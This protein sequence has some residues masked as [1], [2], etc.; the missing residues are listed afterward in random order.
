MSIIHHI[1]RLKDKN[2]IIISLDA[3]KK[4]LT[5][6]NILPQ[7]KSWRDYEY[8]KHIST[9]KAIYKS[10]ANII[11]NREQLQAF[12]L[13]SGIRQGSLFS[14]NL[15]KIVFSASFSNNTTEGDQEDVNKKGRNH[16]ILICRWYNF[17]F[18]KTQPG[19]PY[20]W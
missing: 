16:S 11:F 8:K 3:E 10:T 5:K 9:T 6:S 18:K 14:P 17:I 2:N 12:P 4:P 19:N 1:N 15:L 20:N 7:Q 13:K